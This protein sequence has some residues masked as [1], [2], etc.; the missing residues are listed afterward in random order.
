M[1]RKIPQERLV[2]ALTDLQKAL[3]LLRGKVI[4]EKLLGRL[5]VWRPLPGP[6]FLCFSAHP[7]EIFEIA[8]VNE[9]IWRSWER[10]PLASSGQ[11]ARAPRR[12]FT[13]DVS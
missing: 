12:G 1:E 3:L 13:K 8:Q 5:N 4:L 10:W 2:I 11:D 7:R 9:G 6:I